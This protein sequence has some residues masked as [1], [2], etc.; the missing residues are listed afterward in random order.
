MHEKVCTKFGSALFSP[1][2]SNILLYSSV[3]GAPSWWSP[4]TAAASATAAGSSGSSGQRRG[5]AH[6][7]RLIATTPRGR[8]HDALSHHHTRPTLSG[9]WRSPPETHTH[10]RAPPSPSSSHLPVMLWQCKLLWCCC[11][12]V[13]VPRLLSAETWEEVIRESFI[14]QFSPPPPLFSWYVCNISLDIW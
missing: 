1:T 12:T 13:A 11:R 6:L 14:T 8:T 5:T 4:A 3:L 10:T 7:L 2:F 9:L